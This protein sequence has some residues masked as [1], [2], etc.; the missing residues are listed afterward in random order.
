MYRFLSFVVALAIFAQ[1]A[2]AQVIS[3]LNPPTAIDSVARTA[4]QAAQ[5][6]ASA[7]CQPMAALPPIEV[8]GGTTGTGQNCRLAD[9]ANNR[10]SRTGLFTVGANGNIV[11]SGST[12]CSWS[13]PLPAG[14]ASYPMFFTSIGTGAMPSVRCRVITSTNTGFSAQCSQAAASVS[15]LGAAVE[16]LATSGTQVYALA[17]PSTQA[18][19]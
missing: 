3:A 7:A 16:L 8:P 11:C 19:L 13:V 15:I 5:D 2:S 17:L 14:A 18:S 9:A 12:T 6:A 10:I 1:P 4:A